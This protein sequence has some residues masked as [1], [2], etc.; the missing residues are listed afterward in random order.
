[1][2]F[3]EEMIVYRLT[4]RLVR[5]IAGNKITSRYVEK[6]EHNVHRGLHVIPNKLLLC[7][8]TIDDL[9]SHR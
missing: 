6:E 2:N 5:T 1:M 7:E 4:R 3:H 9:M 8:R